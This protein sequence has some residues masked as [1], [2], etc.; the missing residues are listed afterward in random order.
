MEQGKSKVQ[1]K[2][3]LTSSW[4]D[5][6]YHKSK[7]HYQCSEE[8]TPLYWKEMKIHITKGLNTGQDKNM[9]SEGIM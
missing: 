5:R 2:V 6:T 7:F 3:S 1:T 4:L 9:K 8:D